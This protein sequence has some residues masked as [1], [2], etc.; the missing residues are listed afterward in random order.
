MVYEINGPLFFGA[1]NTFLDVLND[2]DKKIHI[3]IFDMSKVTVL[4]A[5]AFDALERI[6][7]RCRISHI[8][9]LFSGVCEQPMKL[10]TNLGKVEGIKTEM[11]FETV[12][13][14]YNEAENIVEIHHKVR[15]HK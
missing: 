10:L 14:A 4:D 5:T 2:I 11:F 6:E 8:L 15:K 9:P 7:K 3:I 1:A 12:A 13:D